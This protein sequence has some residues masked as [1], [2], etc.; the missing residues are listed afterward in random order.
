MDGICRPAGVKDIS[1]CLVLQIF[2]TSGAG[3]GPDFG[4]MKCGVRVQL[5]LP[6]FTRGKLGQSRRGRGPSLQPEGWRRERL[7]FSFTW[8]YRAARSPSSGSFWRGPLGRSALFGWM[9]LPAPGVGFS[10]AMSFMP[11]TIHLVAINID[12]QIHFVN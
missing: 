6:G 4:Q 8:F 10:G 1:W 12:C 11:N 2:R 7:I 3:D 5:V 9:P